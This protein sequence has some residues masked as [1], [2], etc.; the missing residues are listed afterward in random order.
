MPTNPN[1]A[2]QKDVDNFGYF[3]ES[4]DLKPSADEIKKLADSQ[5]F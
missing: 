4:S 2:T 5:D 3:G 1:T